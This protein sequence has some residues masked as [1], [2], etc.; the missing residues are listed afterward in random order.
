VRC[1]RFSRR[2]QE[3]LRELS[4]DYRR[5]NLSTDHSTGQACYLPLELFDDTNFEAREPHDWVRVGSA[6]G[7]F[8]LAGLTDFLTG[9]RIVTRTLGFRYVFSALYSM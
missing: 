2:A 1:P 8:P 6:H 5:F 7:A 9:F 3:L 4:V